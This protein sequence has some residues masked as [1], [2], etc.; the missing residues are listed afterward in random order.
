METKWQTQKCNCLN[1]I[2]GI[3]DMTAKHDK[4][5]SPSWLKID[6]HVLQRDPG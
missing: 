2:V 5:D 1:T 3:Y 6:I 4:K